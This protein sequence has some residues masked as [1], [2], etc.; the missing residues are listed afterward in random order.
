MSITIAPSILSANFARLEEEV[1]KIEDAG[2]EI[3]HIDIMDGHFVPNLTIGPGVVESCG[4]YLPWI[5][6]FT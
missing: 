4:R 2:A 1:K 5:L 3:L 6:M